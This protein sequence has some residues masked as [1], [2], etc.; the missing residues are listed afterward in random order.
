VRPLCR[1]CHRLKT[2]GLLVPGQRNDPGDPPGTIIWV[3]RT[4]RAYAALPRVPLSVTVRPA[5][6]PLLAGLS[7]GNPRPADDVEDPP[8]F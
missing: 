5:G 1:P 3:T 6:A 8:P 4:G 7:G 2:A